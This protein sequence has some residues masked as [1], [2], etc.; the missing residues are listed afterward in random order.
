MQIQPTDKPQWPFPEWRQA[1]DGQWQ[2]VPA[3]KTKP[4]TKRERIER[5][6]DEIGEAKW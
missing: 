4:E 2:M 5:L 3:P 6:A 1:P